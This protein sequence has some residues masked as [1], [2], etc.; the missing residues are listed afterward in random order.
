MHSRRLI[1]LL[2]V[3]F[4]SGCGYGPDGLEGPPAANLP[5]GLPALPRGAETPVARRYPAY[6]WPAE[7]QPPLNLEFELAEVPPEIRGPARLHR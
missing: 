2:T 3:A 4:L 7:F 6:S 1:I 5:A